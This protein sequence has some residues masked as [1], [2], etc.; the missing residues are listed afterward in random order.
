[1]MTRN[2]IHFDRFAGESAGH[3][4]GLAIDIRDAVAA[5]GDVIDDKCHG[6]ADLEFLHGL[7]RAQIR[8]SKSKA[9]PS[10]KSS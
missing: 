7:L 8:N 2:M 6:A 4:D 10:I 3:I 9:A 1:M 5:M